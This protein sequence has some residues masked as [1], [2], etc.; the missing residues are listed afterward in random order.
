MLDV[1]V[2]QQDQWFGGLGYALMNSPQLARPA[3][4]TLSSGQDGEAVGVEAGAIQ[5]A[6]D[7]GRAIRTAI[8]DQND[9]ER[10]SI[11][12]GQQAADAA[13]DD[14]GLVARRHNDHDR[15]AFPWSAWLQR[16]AIGPKAPVKDK[17]I[18]PGE[19]GDRSKNRHKEEFQGM[20]SRTMLRPRRGLMKAALPDRFQQQNQMKLFIG[21]DRSSD[22][23]V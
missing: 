8:I 20:P 16:W 22:K 7:R 23:S 9:F 14:L 19:A 15:R 21:L 10:T 3:L 1:G 13:R 2:G 17:K 4:G 11:I 5:G 18:K 6:C 12:L